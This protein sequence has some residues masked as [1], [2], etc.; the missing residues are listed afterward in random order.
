MYKTT[1]FGR[2]SDTKRQKGLKGQVSPHL[3]QNSAQLLL[4]TA[5]HR[6]HIALALE[7]ALIVSDLLANVHRPHLITVSRPE[8]GKQPTSSRSSDAKKSGQANPGSSFLELITICIRF[9][10]QKQICFNKSN[11]L[12]PPCLFS[13]CK[14]DLHY[15]RIAPGTPLKKDLGTDKKTAA[16]M[17]TTGPVLPSRRRRIEPSLEMPWLADDPGWS[18]PAFPRS[19]DIASP[20]NKMHRVC[21]N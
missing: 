12:I 21:M 19:R 4:L 2:V 20:H 8:I 9:A 5:Q 11:S 3:P 15:M 7:V 1:A 6:D 18:V 16:H 13:P 17:T 10:I 14:L